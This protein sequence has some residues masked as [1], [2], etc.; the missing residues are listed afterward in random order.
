MTLV[1][2]PDTGPPPTHVPGKRSWLPAMHRIGFVVHS[3]G[4]S[5][6]CT[7]RTLRS[8]CR[9]A[10][11]S[12]REGRKQGG[13][14]QRNRPHEAFGGPCCGDLPGAGSDRVSKDAASG[15]ADEPGV[16]GVDVRRRTR[17]CASVSGRGQAHTA[18]RHDLGGEDR[19]DPGPEGPPAQ[20]SRGTSR[21]GSDQDL[22]PRRRQRRLGSLHQ[23]NLKQSP[24]SPLGPRVNKSW[25]SPWTP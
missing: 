17:R 14:A 20:R 12:L 3:W 2:V 13:E 4:M 8:I 16:R 22:P 18:R 7:G 24:D 25:G 11:R 23:S 15:P 19:P 1:A 21:D 10:P 9:P 6:S 5:P